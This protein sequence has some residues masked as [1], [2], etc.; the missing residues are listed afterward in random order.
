MRRGCGLAVSS[1]L[2]FLSI[3]SAPCHH[4]YASSQTQLGPAVLISEF[5][6][7]AL[8][9]DEYLVLVNR[10]GAVENMRN[11]S[12]TDGEGVL[13]FVRDYYIAPSQALVISTNRSSYVSAFGRDPDIALDQPNVSDTISVSG[14]FRLADAGDSLSLLTRS[15]ELADFVKYGRCDEQ[16]PGWLGPG[17][18]SFR[19]GE[20][21]K[22]VS[23][24][25]VTC[26]T[27]TAVDWMPF[28]EYRYGYSE[29]S[30][31]SATVPSGG[32]T[33]FASPDCSLEVVLAAIGSARYH[34]KL[35][36]Y[37]L[38]SV[39]ICRALAEVCARGVRVD[40][41]VDGAPAGGVSNDE[42]A[43][44]S[45]LAATGV[46]VFALN[47]NLTENIVQ[48]VGPLHSKY[49]VI[50]SERLVILSE[51]F[52]SSG[53]PADKLCGNRG[54]GVMM[55]E[56]S[57]ARYAEAIFD[58]D[59]RASRKDVE[60][61]RTDQ[62]FDPQAALPEATPP[63]HTAGVLV[64]LKTTKDAVVS[65]F[66]SP[67]SSV[68]QPFLL[69]PV[70]SASSMLIEQFQVDLEWSTRWSS[71]SELSPLIEGV[72]EG[73]RRGA[74]VRML[75]D[76]TWFNAARNGAVLA[77]LQSES[78]NASCDAEFRLLDPDN[79][80]AMIHNKGAVLNGT[81]TLV[82]SNNW[83]YSSFA[84]NRELAAFI[85]S[86]EIA[87]FFSRAF[88][89]DWSPD[90]TPPDACAGEDMS[91]MVG[92]TVRLTAESSVDDRCIAHWFWDVNADGT[93]EGFSQE[94][95][96]YATKPG[97]ITVELVVED[98]WGNRDLDRVVVEVLGVSDARPH[99]HGRPPAWAVASSGCIGLALGSALAR[100]MRKA[101]AQD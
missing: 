86:D 75:M 1:A 79:P 15:G 72:G 12:V 36:T 40:V 93:F 82:S 5:Y 73:M 69:S 50:D 97:S 42:R 58:S 65:L 70:S 37:E 71:S 45:V 35:C 96:F 27:D 48:H 84:R 64:P 57:L 89:L 60:D 99:S 33:A 30:P 66:P 25:G 74:E 51:N 41:L 29:F 20:I 77:Y 3:V 100:R 23:I 8:S 34:V 94:I 31:L 43:C 98:G 14:T 32:M 83:V 17:L 11:W 92:Q 53:L 68:T 44:L 91:V 49:M 78:E 22:R 18:P 85:D 39:E 63:N 10:G 19:P 16:S 13:W 28:R 56:P 90:E 38:D 7:A 24:N 4:T 55:S 52:V 21:A 46:R 81:R 76:S 54:W 26:D 88:E 59:S 62:R 101:C 67:D 61:W 47:G 9:D 2:L 95:E 6:P 87:M 80:V